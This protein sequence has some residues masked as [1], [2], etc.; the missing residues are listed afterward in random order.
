MMY[1]RYPGCPIERDKVRYVLAQCV[2]FSCE[3]SKAQR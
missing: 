3:V 2:D 1:S